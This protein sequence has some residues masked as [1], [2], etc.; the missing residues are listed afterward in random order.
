MTPKMR[1]SPSA[2]SASRPASSR[3]LRTAS[4]KKMSSVQSMNSV[5]RSRPS[6]ETRPAAA[7][8]DEEWCYSGPHGEERSE[9]ARLEPWHHARSHRSNPHIRL[10][11]LIARAQLRRRPARL[12][13]PALE[14]VGAVGDLE[15]LPDVLLDDQ[16][17]VAFAAQPPHQV[18]HLRDVDRRAPTRR[19]FGSTWGV[20]QRD[21]E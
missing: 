16:H 4:R 5:L 6:F 9:A 19:A 12:E 20:R 21:S 11:D 18:E 14:E 17:R 3:P 10:A 7:P 8:Q 15:H 1:L 13:A 2:S